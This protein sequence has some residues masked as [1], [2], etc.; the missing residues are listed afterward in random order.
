MNAAANHVLQSTLFAVLASLVN[1]TLLRKNSPQA[2]CWVWLAASVKFLIPFAA[3]TALGGRFGF[4]RLAAPETQAAFYYAMDD[5]SRRIVPHF[6]P[7][8]IPVSGNPFPM[9]LLT[10]WGCG[11]ALVTASWWLRW[12][13]VCAVARAATPLRVAEGI[14]VLSS[15]ERA[16]EPGVFGLFRPVILVPEAI[17]K[18]LS[19]EQF[20]AILAHECCHA[21]RRDNL[22]AAVQMLVEA[23]FWFHPL[24]WWLGRQITRERERICD[25]DVLRRNNDPAVYAEGILNVCKFYVESPLRCVA[26]VTGSNLKQRIEEIMTHRGAGKL[27]LAKKALLAA[28]LAVAVAVPVWIGLLHAPMLQAQAPAT[29]QQ[30]EIASIKPNNSGENNHSIRVK[31]GGRMVA[32]NASLWALITAAYQVQDYQISGGPSWLKSANFDIDAKGPVKPDIPID[33]QISQ[34][35]QALLADRFQLRLHREA[36]EMPIYMILIAR[37]GPKLES[38]RGADCFDPRA[39]IPPPTPDARPCGGFNMNRDRILGSA[40]PMARLALALSRIVGRPVVD[41]TR[42]AGTF[43][44]TLHWTPDDTQAFLAPP[45]PAAAPPDTSAPSIFTALQEQ[46][47]LRLEPQKGPVEVLVIDSAQLPSAN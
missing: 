39:G 23:L 30:F 33:E 36:R 2:R 6:V 10:V 9:L 13:Q 27:G 11:A 35:T 41:K 1:L 46:L 14:P 45:Q 28:A 24:V 20:E 47:G 44:I 25:E 32:L 31:P 29:D 19:P 22:A 15:R 7:S 17:A 21:R 43:D 8:A 5:V 40:V 26:G 18:R 37:N 34:M 3:L 16:F 12:R 42:L 38:V 4:M